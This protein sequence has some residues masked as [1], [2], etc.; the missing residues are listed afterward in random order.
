MKQ[1]IEVEYKILVSKDQLNTLINLLCI[2]P[3]F[4]EQVN[5]Y[6]DTKDFAL[7]QQKIA[8][9]VRKKNNQ[10]VATLKTPYGQSSVQ[11]FEWPVPSL[12]NFSKNH[13]LIEKLKE[14]GLPNEVFPTFSLRTLRHTEIIEQAELCFDIN[15]YGSIVDFEIEYEQ[16]NPHDGRLVFQSILHKIDLTYST[17]CKSKIIRAMEEKNNE[18]IT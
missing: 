9:R 11:E 2:T 6:F 18:T 4:I 13:I 15:E 10:F 8:L 14:L 12:E 7:A 3:N 16:T 1:N 17:N 5:T